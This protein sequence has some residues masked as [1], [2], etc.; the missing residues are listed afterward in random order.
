MTEIDLPPVTRRRIVRSLQGAFEDGGSTREELIA[1]AMRNDA[2]QQVIAAL[3]RLRPAQYR[4][5][6]QLW[7]DLHDV[8]V[9]T[10]WLTGPAADR[11]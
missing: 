3:E 8:P 4:D 10:D 7:V 2:D 9:D 6:R 5:I 1:A 11:A